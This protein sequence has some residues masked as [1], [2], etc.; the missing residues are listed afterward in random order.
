MHIGK[1]FT[2]MKK[3][4]QTIHFHE[5]FACRF[6]AEQCM[7]ALRQWCLNPKEIKGLSTQGSGID[8]SRVRNKH[9]GTLINF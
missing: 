2:K 5:K 8:Y 6:T 7:S 4:N 9:T 3:K 1:K